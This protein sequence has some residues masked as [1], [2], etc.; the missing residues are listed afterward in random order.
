MTSTPVSSAA[1]AL[2]KDASY[3]LGRPTVQVLS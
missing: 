2:T 1:I 3:A